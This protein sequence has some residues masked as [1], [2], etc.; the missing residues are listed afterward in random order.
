MTSAPLEE[1]FPEGTHYS[2]DTRCITVSTIDDDDYEENHQ[3]SV[4]L[5]V[6]S[7][8]SILIVGSPAVITIS[9]QDNI[10]RLLN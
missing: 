6:I 5:R 4:E 8:D 10:G 3:F 9:I 2:N 7:N 1:L